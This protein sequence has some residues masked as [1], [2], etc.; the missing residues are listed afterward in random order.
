[1]TE[2]GFIMIVD[3]EEGIRTSLGLLLEKTGY[4]VGLAA[5]G[6]EA[7]EMAKEGPVNLVLLDIKLP[8]T[9]GVQLIT[10]LQEI[11]PG[12][13]IIM[14]TG[15]ASVESAVRALSAGAFGYITKPINLDELLLS[16]RNALDYHRRVI[17]A[18]RKAEE[19]T[20]SLAKIQRENPNPVF[21]V[22]YDGSL[23]FANES[24]ESMFSEG[25][26][27]G[28]RTIPEFIEKAVQV[29]GVRRSPFYLERAN[30]GRTYIISVVPVAGQEYVNF[31]GLDITGSMQAETAVRE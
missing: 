22:G 8:D 25:H 7:L 9:D 1:M 30:G 13:P 23:L 14:I 6:H 17:E 27:T 29:A 31:Y 3:D 16:I 21:R 19:E 24:A 20:E 28:G 10:P 4:G 26:L 5:T 11:N 15:F 12:V 2:K 18:G